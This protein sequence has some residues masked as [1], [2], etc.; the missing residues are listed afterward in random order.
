MATATFKYGEPDVAPYTPGSAV[1]EGDVV[2]I[3]DTPVIAHT[4]IAANTL[5]TVA[6]RGGF[7]I[8]P[9]ASSG[10]IAGRTKVWWNAGASQVT[11]TAS[12]HKAFGFTDPAGA[13]DGDT[14]VIVEHFPTGPDA[15]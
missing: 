9:K 1:A 15:T 4:D 3:G 8:M 7:Y 10:A 5:G 11:T 2:V 13:A 14:T 6:I 12:T